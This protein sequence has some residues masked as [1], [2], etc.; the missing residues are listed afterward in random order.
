MQS[1]NFTNL[2][3]KHNELAKH[4][5]LVNMANELEEEPSLSY[6]IK[7]HLLKQVNE[8]NKR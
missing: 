4:L 8:F 2:A 3:K 7:Y 5:I 6:A 1:L